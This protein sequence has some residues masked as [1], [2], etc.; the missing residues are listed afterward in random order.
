MKI[1]YFRST[2]P[3]STSSTRSGAISIYLSISIYLYI[4]DI[5]I[6]IYLD[7]F[8]DLSIYTSIYIIINKRALRSQHEAGLHV[9]NSLGRT[10]L[11]YAALGGMDEAAKALLAAGSA[12][13][14]TPYTLNPQPYTLDP[15]HPHT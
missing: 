11:H 5:S 14:P 12:L 15:V 10:P 3:G 1:L 13:N 2:M 7:L 9:S 4:S 6:S 8:V